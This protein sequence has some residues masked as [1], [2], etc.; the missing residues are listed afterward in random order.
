M[1]VNIRVLQKHTQQWELA[2]QARLGV[3][4][5]CTQVLQARLGVTHGCTQV[6]QAHTLNLWLGA[7]Q[8]NDNK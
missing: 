5:G 6:L 3:P 1:W 2:L 8:D 7:D 4:H